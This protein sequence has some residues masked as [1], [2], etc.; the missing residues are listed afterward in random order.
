MRVLLLFFLTCSSPLWP[1]AQNTPAHTW[2]ITGKDPTGNK[3]FILLIQS[4]TKETVVLVK[5]I[6]SV[7]QHALQQD[8]LYIEYR[9]GIKNAS[10]LDE[11]NVL[12]AQLGEVVETYTVYTIDTLTCTPDWSARLTNIAETASQAADAV[13]KGSND[14]A[15]AIKSKTAFHFRYWQGRKRKK[16]LYVPDPKSSS[17]LLY[18]LITQTLEAY[19]QI[20]G[21]KGILQDEQRLGY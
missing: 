16:D 17:P 21:G 9:T 2:E 10:S 12:A 11:V 3:G 20:R 15:G 5:R 4:Y 8:P 6:D 14:Q 7:R 18:Q 1:N 13:L 19:Q